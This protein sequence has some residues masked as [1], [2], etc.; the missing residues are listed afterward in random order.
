MINIEPIPDDPLPPELV[1]RG[2]AW[3]GAVSLGGC[4][5]IGFFIMFLPAIGILV[6]FGFTP[7]QSFPILL[8]LAAVVSA[9]VLR[10][11]NRYSQRV[12]QKWNQRIGPIVERS[13]MAAK[14]YGYIESGD[15]ASGRHRVTISHVDAIWPVEDV[16]FDG[17]GPNQIVRTLE[18]EYVYFCAGESSAEFEDVE[19]DTCFLKE[20]IT[21]ELGANLTHVEGVAMT[22]R[23]VPVGRDEIPARVL[24]DGLLAVGFAIL[25]DPDVIRRLPPIRPA[26]A[27]D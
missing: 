16:A 10:R 17:S 6:D 20:V 9:I 19:D 3:I 12:N 2:P 4:L 5:S 1:A 13:R 23:R 7:L 18:E 24:P 14:R 15:A 21:L 11:A 8:V 25:D 27:Q 22:G 26:G